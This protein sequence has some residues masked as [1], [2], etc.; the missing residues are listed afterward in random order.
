MNINKQILLI[1]ISVIL[2]PHLTSAQELVTGFEAGPSNGYAFI[3]PVFSLPK[4]GK[5][6]FIIRPTA[7]YLYYKFRDAAGSTTVNSPGLSLQI[8][9]RRQTRRLNFTIAPG[10]EVRW[11]SRKLAN[12]QKVERTQT[13]AIVGADV[14]FQATPLTNLNFISSYGSANRYLFTRGGIKRQITNKKFDKPVS[15][16]V[17]GEITGQGNR[18][19]RQFGGGGMFEIGF[20][21]KK[22]SLQFRAGYNRQTFALGPAES[23]PYFGAGIYRRF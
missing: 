20:L 17:G 1:A 12:G 7:S 22:T 4:S 2:L 14:F 16:S 10:I 6:V 13:G 3:S 9:Y 23:K 5:N 11:D 8:G 21:R 18:D 19:I 15:F